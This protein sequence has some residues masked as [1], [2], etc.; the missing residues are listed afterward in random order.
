[1]KTL[2]KLET[3]W[4]ILRCASR[5]L[6]LEATTLRCFP[7]LLDSFILYLGYIFH[8]AGEENWEINVILLCAKLDVFVYDGLFT[9][10]SIQKEL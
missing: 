4:G 1:M 8:A 7:S 2:G 5:G 9:R 6:P 3:G 10:E